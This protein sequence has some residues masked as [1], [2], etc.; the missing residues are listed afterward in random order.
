MNDLTGLATLS[1]LFHIDSNYFIFVTAGNQ[2]RNALEYML[3][4]ERI[5]QYLTLTVPNSLTVL[6]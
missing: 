2:L 1:V 3:I 6:V 5:L 4:K